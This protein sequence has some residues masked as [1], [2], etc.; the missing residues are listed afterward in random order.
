MASNYGLYM[1]ARR[2]IPRISPETLANM[3]SMSYG[4]IAFEVLT[5][6][7]E[8]RS[9]KRPCVGFLAD[10]YEEEKIPRK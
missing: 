3:G 5:P 7:S 10:A 1:V 9:L 8:A 2:D 6:F 4:E